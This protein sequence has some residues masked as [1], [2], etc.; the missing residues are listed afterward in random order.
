M[1]SS[2]SHLSP[3]YAE[4]W[5][6][7][8]FSFLHGASHP[9]ELVAQAKTLGYRSIAITD[10]CSYAGI[11]RA[12]LAAKEHNIHLIVGTCTRAQFMLNESEG[13]TVQLLLLAK[14]LTGYSAISQ[15][16][17]RARRRSPK[18]EYTLLQRDL[19]DALPGVIVIIAPDPTQQQATLP[20]AITWLAKRYIG[21][22]WIGAHL[23]RCGYQETW[24]DYLYSLQAITSVPLVAVGHV[25]MH[26]RQR[27]PLQD[28]L[29]AIA[30]NGTL[31]EVRPHLLPN[32]EHAL[33]S[34]GELQSL[35]PE[36]LLA[37]TI[38]IARQCEFQLT[39][40]RYQYPREVVPQ[41]HSPS[42]YLREVAYEG[43]HQ[44][45]KGQIPHAISQQ[46]D[47]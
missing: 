9:E 18:G 44:R 27:K 4:L 36:H 14:N 22:L 20:S 13:L 6:Q 19:A 8:N 3:E 7:S 1:A 38:T 10:E 45:F 31:D 17:T 32:A 43:A 25:L 33:K 5:C 30:H 39:E 12:H 40:L 24:L 41:H 2:P 47:H 46:I 11:V 23:M 28:A 34:I 35:Y 37:A 26:Q 16:I 21:R 29:T 15:L 42:S